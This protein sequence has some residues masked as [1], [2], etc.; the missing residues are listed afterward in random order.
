[1]FAVFTDNGDEEINERPC[2]VWEGIPSLRTVL[3][4]LNGDEFEGMT[5]EATLA[6]ATERINLYERGDG[7]AFGSYDGRTVTVSYDNA[8]SEPI[9]E[10]FRRDNAEIAYQAVTRLYL[11]IVHGQATGIHNV[12]A[13]RP[14]P[15]RD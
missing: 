10:A 7:R 6:L 5:L 9:D 8:E 12:G 4:H 2:F 3:Q 13:G 1:M 15:A 11:E 14:V